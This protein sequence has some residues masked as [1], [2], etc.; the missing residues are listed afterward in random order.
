MERI[1]ID[2]ISDR[3]KMEIKVGLLQYKYIQDRYND[4]T[5][6]GKKADEDFIDVYTNF[7]LKSQGIMKLPENRRR[8]FK[9]LF[10]RTELK[11]MDF[12][13]LLNNLKVCQKRK[14]KKLEMYEFSFVTKLLHTAYPE[15]YPIYDSKV[16]NYLKDDPDVDLKRIIGEN[17]IEKI[18]HN[19]DELNKWYKNFNGKE[20]WIKKFN[21]LFP[22]FENISWYKK[23]DFIIFSCS[24]TN[25]M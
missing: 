2:N 1:K 8:Y 17:K 4:L 24:K 3:Q 18:E 11:S 25:N 15:D 20:E 16:F 23:I 5:K 6:N 19:W 9:L 14:D 22:E 13:E 12:K 7:Y 21:E 10:N